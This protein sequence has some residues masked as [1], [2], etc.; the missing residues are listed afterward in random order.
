MIDYVQVHILSS[1]FSQLVVS[2][3]KNCLKNDFSPG[4]IVG[5]LFVVHSTT[6]IHSFRFFFWFLFKNNN[7]NNIQVF[8]FHRTKVRDYLWLLLVFAAV[9]VLGYSLM[10]L[11]VMTV[12]QVSRRF[13]NL[14]FVLWIVR[15]KTH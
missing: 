3:S 15:T 4:L 10:E 6:G 12:D 9:M 13:A 14:P 2:S 5:K 11:M 8:I 1:N 7:N